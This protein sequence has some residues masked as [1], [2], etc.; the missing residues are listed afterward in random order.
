MY[1][2]DGYIVGNQRDI[3][4]QLNIMGLSENDASPQVIAIPIGRI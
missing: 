3:Q 1:I 2:Y 4:N